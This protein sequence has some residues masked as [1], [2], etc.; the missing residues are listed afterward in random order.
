[1]YCGRTEHR[2]AFH[3]EWIEDPVDRSQLASCHINLLLIDADLSRAL[4]IQ[5]G[6]VILQGDLLRGGR[7]RAASV[8]A[9]MR[10]TSNSSCVP[11]PAGPSIEMSSEGP[12]RT[13]MSSVT[14]AIADAS[15]RSSLN[16]ICRYTVLLL[17]ALRGA[18]LRALCAKF[19]RMSTYSGSFLDQA[20]SSDPESHTQRSRERGRIGVRHASAPTSTAHHTNC[21]NPPPPVRARTDW[22]S[23]RLTDDV[24]SGLRTSASWFAA[25]LR[26]VRIRAASSLK[27]SPAR[28]VD[29]DAARHRGRN[30]KG[31]TCIYEST[32]DVRR[33]GLLHG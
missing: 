6:D 21:R 20:P 17:P 9:W 4:R 22:M 18:T 7:I 3:S 29:A 8:S 1:M 26:A 15:S 31:G 11:P 5:L 24:A 10:T 19:H 25:S 14:V 30:V 16:R 32:A 12:R 27:A 28:A 13:A 33:S 23:S 2:S